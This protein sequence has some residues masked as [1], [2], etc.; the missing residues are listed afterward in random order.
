MATR[1]RI[2]EVYRDLGCVLNDPTAFGLGPRVP[3]PL[4]EIL[5]AS[6][7]KLMEEIEEQKLEEEEDELSLEAELSQDADPLPLSTSGASTNA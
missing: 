6:R 5:T 3:N 2:I 1:N 7:T 4:V